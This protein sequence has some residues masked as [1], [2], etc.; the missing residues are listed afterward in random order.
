M[1]SPTVCL[2][3]MLQH[4]NVNS[5]VVTELHSYAMRSI[6][7]TVFRMRKMQWRLYSGY[8]NTADLILSLP[9]KHRSP[10]INIYI[11]TLTLAT[12]PDSIKAQKENPPFT[13]LLELPEN[14]GETTVS[15]T[16]ESQGREKASQ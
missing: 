16:P 3:L 5:F 12:L 9:A 8:D 15:E 4:F 10:V 11:E 1:K 6:S 14:V 7:F 2:P 13:L